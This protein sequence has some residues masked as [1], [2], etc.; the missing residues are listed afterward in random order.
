M[1][2]SFHPGRLAKLYYNSGTYA[3]PTWVEIVR[4]GDVAT[5]MSKNTTTVVTRESANQKTV[6][7]SKVFQITATYYEK[8]AAD[9]VLA[10]I[11]TSFHADSP[12]ATGGTMELAAMN[13][14]IATDGST[15][16]RGFFAVTNLERAEPVGDAVSRAVT[17][18]EVDHEEDS[19]VVDVAPYTIST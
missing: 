16:I 1:A 15:G 14:S 8:V 11:K 7:G 6:I 13:E 19:S 17:W 5:P 2:E 10:A 3:S 18:D 12:D 4:V 9:T